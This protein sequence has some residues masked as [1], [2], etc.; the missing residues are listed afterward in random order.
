[1][2]QQDSMGERS[3]SHRSARGVTRIATR[4]A[5]SRLGS[6]R[7]ISSALAIVGALALLTVA[8]CSGSSSPS[9]AT[10]SSAGLSVVYDSHVIATNLDP[11]IGVDA[12]SLLFIRNVY[13]GLMEYAPG[14][15]QLRP[16]LATSYTTS[17][18]GLVYTFQLRKGV[19]FH[20]GTAFDSA[21]VVTSLNRLKAINQG[22]AS[23]LDGVSSWAAEG[24]YAVA[25]TLSAPD[26]Y[27]IGNLPW[28]PI[29][30]PA[31]IA[32]HKTSKD[33][34]A[35]NWFASH[36]DGTGP[37]K[38]TS[39]VANSSISLEKYDGYW[40]KWP[41]NVATSVT[42][43]Q[44]ADPSTRI[45]LLES[46]QATFADG[47]APSDL[48][49][50]KKSPNVAISESPG[51]SLRTIMLNTTAKGPMSDPNFREALILAFP[52]QAYF[53]YYQG[54]GQAA[55][56][57]I[58]PGMTGYNKSL[59]NFTQNLTRAKQLLQAGGW[60]NSGVKLTYVSVQGE[61][62]GQYA[63]TLLQ[64]ALAQFGITVSTEALPW[65]QIPPLMASPKSAFD[66]SFLNLSENTND[67]TSLI[68]SSYSSQEVPAKGGFNFANLTNP[69]IDSLITSAREAKNSTE[70]AA[71]TTS[72]S[73]QLLDTYS[74]I[75]CIAPINAN[76]VG[77]AWADVK[78]D[79]LYNLNVLRFFYAHKGS[80]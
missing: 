75:F 63:G 3:R 17:D 69:K 30:S 26:S 50:L 53:S 29:V 2:H 24:K 23:Y 8:A 6:R 45:Q 34:W 58:P 57:P 42:I 62:Y 76:P 48:T 7:R 20:D 73:Q 12:D 39:F 32:A 67:P 14:S 31:G 71:L 13:E 54:W 28:L 56:G 70:A 77:K 16:A 72:L 15:T 55:N 25:I 46:G 21:S 1:M 43:S 49:A 47:F 19:T 27:F 18:G 10:G 36:E 65:P 44:V 35:M 38:L 78:F 68:Q 4:P 5:G 52:Y 66:L 41:A 9:A 60:L 64:S 37:Y 51:L 80:G 61:S 33:P 11:D 40:Q 79:S 59:P 22:P 74:N